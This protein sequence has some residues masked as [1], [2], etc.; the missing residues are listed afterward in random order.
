MS[1]FGKFVLSAKKKSIQN[2]QKSEET[3]YVFLPHYLCVFC[4]HYCFAINVNRYTYVITHIYV[5][6]CVPYNYVMISNDS[7]AEN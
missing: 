4:S 6:T 7:V 5:I 1:K 3:S 2:L